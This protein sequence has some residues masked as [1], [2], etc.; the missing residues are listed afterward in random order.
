[1]YMTQTHWLTSSATFALSQERNLVENNTSA[2]FRPIAARLPDCRPITATPIF[3]LFWHDTEV[4][5]GTMGTSTYIWLKNNSLYSFPSLHWVKKGI[6]W[7][8]PLN[9][10]STRLD[11]IAARLPPRLL[12]PTFFLL[13]H[14]TEV[15]MCTSSCIWLKRNCL[16]P[17]L[18]FYWVK[19]RIWCKIPLPPTSAQ[20]AV[21]LIAVTTQIDNPNWP[22]TRISHNQPAK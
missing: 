16:R 4:A 18:P 2:H 9:T 8:I 7:E 1:M 6:W 17:F 5:M 3:F 12:S 10:T 20:L 14:N 11:P 15:A 21:T 22:K 19:K 13:W